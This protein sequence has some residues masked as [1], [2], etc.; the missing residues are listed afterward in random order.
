MS[1]NGRNIDAAPDGK[2]LALKSAESVTDLKVV[3]NWLSEI[4]QRARS[5]K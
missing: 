1:D 5:K 2:I 3:L 4:D